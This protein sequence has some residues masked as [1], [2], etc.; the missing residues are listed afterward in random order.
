MVSNLS[1]SFSIVFLQCSKTGGQ[2][3]EISWFL[4]CFPILSGP[5]LFFFSIASTLLSF[6]STPSTFSFLSNSVPEGSPAQLVSGVHQ[7][8]TVSAPVDRLHCFWSGQ[9]PL[10]PPV[11][12]LAL[13]S[14]GNVFGLYWS[15]L[16]LRSVGCVIVPL[17]FLSYK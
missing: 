13:C 6:N 5:F 2:H 9:T 16:S 10:L 4:F 8:Q 7:A 1:L 12:R 17:C 3:S 11:L 15:F 14:P